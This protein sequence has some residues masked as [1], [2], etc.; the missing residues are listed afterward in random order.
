MLERIAHINWPLQ[1][2]D[3]TEL[4]IIG[5]NTVMIHRPEKEP[6]TVGRFHVQNDGKL[7]LKKL[8]LNDKEHFFRKYQSYAEQKLLVDSLPNDAFIAC[9]VGSTVYYESVKTWRENSRVDD[10]NY[11]VQYFLRRDNMKR[12]KLVG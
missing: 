9:Y 4:H 7:V 8:G 6:Q 1:D 3:G 2:I 10:F 11:G 5:G 12:K